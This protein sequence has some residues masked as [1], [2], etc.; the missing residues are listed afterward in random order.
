MESDEVR[1]ITNQARIYGL[2][3]LPERVGLP[4]GDEFEYTVTFGKGLSFKNGRAAL[5]FIESM[6][7]EHKLK[8][9]P[10]SYR[11]SFGWEI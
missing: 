5:M 2:K 3:C 6:V 9:H 10:G 11:L 4:D 7:K 8:E 1:E